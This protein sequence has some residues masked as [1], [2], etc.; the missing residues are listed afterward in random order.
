[1]LNLCADLCNKFVIR[2]RFRIFSKNR[3]ANYRIHIYHN[4]I[5]MSVGHDERLMSNHQRQ[6]TEIQQDQ[7]ITWVQ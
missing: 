5:S 3:E 6:K 7:E 2:I 4:K 1:M